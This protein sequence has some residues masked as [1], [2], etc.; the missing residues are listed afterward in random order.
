[1]IVYLFCV[2]A[3]ARVGS[4]IGLG[5]GAK[6]GVRDGARGGDRVWRYSKSGGKRAGG[7]PPRTRHEGV[8][9]DGAEL[10]EGLGGK[11]CV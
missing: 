5:F 8:G 9:T 10:A 6:D 11:G 2:C 3:M 7:S 4:R 1:M